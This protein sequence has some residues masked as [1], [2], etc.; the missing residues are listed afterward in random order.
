MV[1]YIGFSLKTNN[2]NCSPRISLCPVD[3][4]WFSASLRSSFSQKN[5]GAILPH[6][7]LRQTGQCQGRF[8]A[9]I[10]SC[11]SQ[12]PGS[13]CPQP[14]DCNPPDNNIMS[15]KDFFLLFCNFI[16]YFPKHKPSC[17]DVEPEHNWAP[18]PRPQRTQY[19][20]WL[21]N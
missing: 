6:R 3:A 8:E 21:Q 13:L 2:I 9:Q 19:F 14:G 20:C 16:K 10:S 12:S 5:F 17:S 11:P 4:R 15:G 1:F 7:K 18:Q